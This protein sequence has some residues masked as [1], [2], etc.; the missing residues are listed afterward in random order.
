MNLITRTLQTRMSI[1]V[2][3]ALR[4]YEIITQTKWHW[5]ICALENMASWIIVYKDEWLINLEM[6]INKI[7]PPFVYGYNLE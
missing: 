2:I 6:V 3:C 4:K 7:T 5:V 1:E